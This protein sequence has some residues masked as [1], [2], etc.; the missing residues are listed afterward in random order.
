MLPL[1]KLMLFSTICFI[2]TK[3]YPCISYNISMSSKI[4]LKGSL[5]FPNL[6][7]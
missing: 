3:W 2:Y 6:M 4:I 7:K 5:E 1:I